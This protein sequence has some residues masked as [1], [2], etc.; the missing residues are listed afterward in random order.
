MQLILFRADDNQERPL[1]LEVPSNPRIESEFLVGRTDDCDVH[2]IDSSVS[3]HHCGIVVDTRAH[4]LRV[5]DKGSRNG[6]FVNDERV[7][8]MRTLQ[9]GDKLTVGFV[10]LRIRICSNRSLWD[11]VAE[12]F[13]AAQVANRRINFRHSGENVPR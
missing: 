3:R 10:P 2:L 12:R 1:V 4:S 13:R 9:D 8:E 5:F 11:N 7:T 6:T